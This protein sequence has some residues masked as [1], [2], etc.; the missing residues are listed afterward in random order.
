MLSF[1]RLSFMFLVV[2]GVNTHSKCQW[3]L[4]HPGAGGQVQYIYP[5]PAVDGRLYY[6]SDMEGMYRSDDFG[7]SWNFQ[8]E[9]FVSTQVYVLISEPEN[10]DVLYAG[11]NIGIHKSMNGGKNWVYLTKNKAPKTEIAT[12]AFDPHNPLTLYAGVCWHEDDQFVEEHKK[13]G[14]IY[15]T[16]DGGV[17]WD[18]LI[19]EEEIIYRQVFSIAIHPAN[20]NEVYLGADQGVYS[21]KD[22]GLSWTKMAPPVESKSGK[23]RGLTITP[24]GKHLYAHYATAIDPDRDPLSQVSYV[25]ETHLFATS[26]PDGSWKNISAN[27]IDS[28]NPGLKLHFWRPVIDP[29]SKGNTHKILMGPLISGNIGLFEGTITIDQDRGISADWKKIF[30]NNPSKGW[31]NKFDYGWNNLLPVARHYA[32]TPPGWNERK[33][34]LGSQQSVYEGDGIHSKTGWVVKTT[35]KVREYESPATANRGTTTAY[36]HRG[37]VC[38]FNYDMHGDS[39]YVVQGQGDNGILESW[40]SGST[41]TQRI[42]DATMYHNSIDGGA[43]WW[44]D[45][46]D[47]FLIIPSSP[48]LLLAG[49]APGFGGGP[50]NNGYLIGI[51]L[52]TYAPTDQWKVLAG[53][54]WNE[55]KAN[56]DGTGIK[57]VAGLPRQ[58]IYTMTYNPFNMKQV[59]VGT[60]QGIFIIDNIFQLYE[61]GEGSFYDI[62][63]GIVSDHSFNWIEFDPQEPNTFYATSRSWENLLF[64][65]STDAGQVWKVSLEEDQWTWEAIYH[66]GAAGNEATKLAVWSY[67]NTTYIAITDNCCP[68]ENLVKLSTDRGKSWNTI[69]SYD[70]ALYLPWEGETEPLP[71]F[72]HSWYLPE[73][74]N[75]LFGAITGYNDQIFLTFSQHQPYGKGYALIKGTLNEN[76]IDWRDWTGKYNYGQEGFFA[77]PHARR[78]RVVETKSKTYLYISTMGMGLWRRAIE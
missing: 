20:S 22:G 50:T 48:K 61:K 53:G 33:I 6:L 31:V 17:S 14:I 39:N 77:F 7:N 27:L 19:F 52:E 54:D 56:G 74:Q 71:E 13:Q 44:I 78:S 47:A 42:F 10:P 1:L 38:T 15:K 68:R 75:M 57:T 36:Q 12:L 4:L 28:V 26:I 46:G 8:G 72:K 23:C 51:K 59:V 64:G 34:W 70:E 18:E 35:K 45:N 3:E 76:G 25:T 60:S 2:W 40:D 63:Q 55:G 58:R 66:N 16:T 24:D 69:L 41:W 62:S 73:K 49:V 21:S 37:I 9:D 43:D 32:Y 30:D 29:R 11:T 5:E 67:K 65:T